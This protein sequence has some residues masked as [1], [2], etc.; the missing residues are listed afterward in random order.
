MKNLRAGVV[1]SGVLDDGRLV[2]VSP[3]GVIIVDDNGEGDVLLDRFT[4]RNPSIL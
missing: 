2:D 1:F 4:G 3:V